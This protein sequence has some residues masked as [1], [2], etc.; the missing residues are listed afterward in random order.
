M[1]GIPTTHLPLFSPGLSCPGHEQYVLCLRPHCSKQIAALPLPASCLRYASP[2]VLE[3]RQ[4]S[5]AQA[6]AATTHLGQS[7]DTSRQISAAVRK[8]ARCT[9][10]NGLRACQSKG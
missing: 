1:E 10:G 5:Q 7:A 4:S 2:A 9:P 8:S 6:L 3:R